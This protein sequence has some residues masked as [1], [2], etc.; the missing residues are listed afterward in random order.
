MHCFKLYFFQVIDIVS[1]HSDCNI[2]HLRNHI[3]NLGSRQC[4]IF[5]PL[6]LSFKLRTPQFHYES[7]PDKDVHNYQNFNDSNP[8]FSALNSNF[9]FVKYSINILYI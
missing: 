6:N 5:F 3:E 4:L 7:V 9:L 2:A 8:I 1:L